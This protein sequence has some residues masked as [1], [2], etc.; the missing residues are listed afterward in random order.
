[1]NPQKKAT[2]HFRKKVKIKVFSK[3]IAMAFNS[4]YQEKVKSYGKDFFKITFLYFEKSGKKP[5]KIKGTISNLYFGKSGP[6]IVLSKSKP[7]YINK[8]QMHLVTTFSLSK[9]KQTNIKCNGIELNRMM[10]EL[11]YMLKNDVN[12]RYVI[13]NKLVLCISRIES[14]EKFINDVIEV[15]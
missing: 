12:C 10:A 5:Y 8:Q 15:M 1:M 7:I 6:K 3:T 2:L 14:G 11:R 4:F 13:L 9:M